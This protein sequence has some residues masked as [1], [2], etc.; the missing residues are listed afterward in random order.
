[1]ETYN[2]STSQN[3]MLEFRIAS[4]GDRILAFLIDFLIIALT[5]VFLE[6]LLNLRDVSPLFLMTFL[7]FLFYHFLFEALFNGQSP[8]KMIFRI[9][10]VKT[11]GSQYTLGNCFIR[12]IFRLL[13]IL[14]TFGV[15]GI[16]F[17]IING[18]GQRLGDVMASTTVL[19]KSKKGKLDNTSW[20]ELEDDYKPTFYE[21]EMLTDKDIQT[22]KEVL[23]ASAERNFDDVAFS[24]I[25][26]TR[27]VIEEKTGIQSD[28][29]NK[30]FLY[31]IV[32]D[33]N[34]IN[35]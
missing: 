1:M 25:N 14:I 29:K 30:E 15:L 27:K 16:T 28:L 5:V 34:A 7:P 31:T 24:L 3:V 18:K 35:R 11:D 33:Y 10:V 8:G 2:L 13:D 26:Q 19:K 32:K 20:V 4:V 21:A 12:W 9:R 23:L 22:I 17:I 6:F